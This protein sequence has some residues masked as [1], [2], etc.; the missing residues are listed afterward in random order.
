[1]NATTRKPSSSSLLP[2][3]LV[4]HQIKVLRGQRVIVDSELAALYGVETKR[5]NEA[6]K[7]NAGKFPP[8]FMFVTTAEEFE[9]L[10]SQIATSN[11]GTPET[12]TGRG[13]RRYLPRVFTEHGA[14]MAATVLSSPRAVEVSIYVVR[15]FV[16]LRELA[17]THQ[18]L[19]KR[20]DALEEKTEALAMSH[21]TFSRNTRNQL[22]QIFDALRE[23][24]APPEPS[25][26]RPIGFLTHEDTKDKPK[27]I[28]KAVKLGRSKKA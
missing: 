19:A 20:L 10:R 16:E 25:P 17:N 8:D 26:K 13:G 15:A 24:A 5:F 22:R 6:V 14:L 9:A 4:T 12:P 18:D 3:E 11:A 1:M 27:G 23:L 28:T 2:L 21:D 7:R